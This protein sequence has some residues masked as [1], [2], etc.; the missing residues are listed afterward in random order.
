M[1]DSADIRTAFWICPAAEV[2]SHFPP[3]GQQLRV[4]C[5]TN[6]SIC[7]L[8]FA[9]AEHIVD[10]GLCCTICR[11][12]RFTSTLKWIAEVF[13]RVHTDEEEL[14]LKTSV[15]HWSHTRSKGLF[16]VIESSKLVAPLIPASELRGTTKSSDKAPKPKPKAPAHDVAASSCAAA[17]SSDAPGSHGSSGSAGSGK[18]IR[19]EVDCDSAADMFSERVCADAE[20]I[21][22]DTVTAAEIAFVSSV[23]QPSP[24]RLRV[25][26]TT[27]G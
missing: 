24:V 19:D 4:C 10:I 11:P 16:A 27:V 9:Q 22:E 14:V 12:L 7:H 3:V 8:F 2:D 21:G 1:K 17:A 13:D 20:E 15:L 26:K 6:Y 25:V 18:D 5:D 23:A